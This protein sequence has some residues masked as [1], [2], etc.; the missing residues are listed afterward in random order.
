MFFEAPLPAGIRYQHASITAG[1]HH[2]LVHRVEQRT[3]TIHGKMSSTLRRLAGGRCE[4]ATHISKLA[5]KQSGKFFPVADSSFQRRPTL[6][7]VKA[8]H[9][10]ISGKELLKP[11][12]LV[13]R[14]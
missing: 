8:F 5:P 9:L 3:H 6:S 10:H 1:D 7:M 2:R 12:Q 13:V 11:T 14:N 4:T